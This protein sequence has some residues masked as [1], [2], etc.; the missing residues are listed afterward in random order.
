MAQ[1]VL[2]PV[3]IP[4]AQFL[5]KV[6]VPVAV[7][8][9]VLWSTQCSSGQVLTCPLL[10]TTGGRC[11]RFS[12]SPEFEDMEKCAQCML[13][14]FSWATRALLGELLCQSGRCCGREESHSHM[15]C[16][17]FVSVTHCSVDVM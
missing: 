12:F 1:T 14:F 6:D 17:Q 2:K 5:A 3:K 15:T 16:H 11:L 4:H 10:R 7:Q 9:Q 13:R 8:R